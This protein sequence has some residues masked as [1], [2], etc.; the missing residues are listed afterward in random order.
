M[1]SGLHLAEDD[2]RGV[3]LQGRFPITN[4]LAIKKVIQLTVHSTA[5]SGYIDGAV[6]IA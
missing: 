2:S 3:A 4:N 6:P 1:E 5:L